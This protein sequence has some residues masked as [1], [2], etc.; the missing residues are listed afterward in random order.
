M[1]KLKDWHQVMA[2][3]QHGPFGSGELKMTTQFSTIYTYF[4]EYSAYWELNNSPRQL[5][6]VLWRPYAYKIIYFL[7]KIVTLLILFIK[8]SNRSSFLSIKLLFS[9][10]QISF[11][12]FLNN[13][14]AKKFPTAI[15]IDILFFYVRSVTYYCWMKNYW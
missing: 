13:L 11:P 6:A 14:P 3:P 2:I 8:T 1:K 10:F 15:A 4:Q 9:G 7:N 5:Q 12:I